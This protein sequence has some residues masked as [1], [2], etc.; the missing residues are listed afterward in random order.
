L[1][2]NIK[3]MPPFPRSFRTEQTRIRGIGLN[4]GIDPVGYTITI[5]PDDSSQA[6]TTLRVEVEGNEARIT[7]LHVRAAQGAGLTAGQL[8]AVDLDQLMRAVMPTGGPA[9]ITVADSTAGVAVDTD[10]VVPA[11]VVDTGG[12]AIAMPV[13][14]TG[15]PETVATPASEPASA[16]TAR[17]SRR[18]SARR[19]AGRG[20]ARSTAHKPAAKKAPA[21]KATAAKSTAAKSTAAKSTAAKSTAAKSTAKRATRKAAPTPAARATKSAA[22]SAA[23]K[24]AAAKSAAA[25]SAAAKSA[26]A[27]SAAAKSVASKAAPAKRAK[28]SGAKPSPAKASSA[29]ARSNG[30][31]RTYRRA[32]ADLAA[33][34]AQTGGVGA[35]ANH[36]QVPR[37]TAQSWVRT[38]RRRTTQ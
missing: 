14:G 4:G 30:S 22:K 36:Y 7:D 38:L 37:H 16:P 9:A 27:K 20:A 2:C 31:T 24:S 6:T 34:L 25:K 33:V 5:A 23:A 17:R 8:P 35:V 11:P 32:P 29:E 15:L 3:S 12:E 26:A 1:C 13:G 18:A 19:S 28:A 10:T 21:K